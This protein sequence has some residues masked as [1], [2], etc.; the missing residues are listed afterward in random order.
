MK[1]MTNVRLVLTAAFEYIL[2]LSAYCQYL[3]RD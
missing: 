2:H 1:R 3:L